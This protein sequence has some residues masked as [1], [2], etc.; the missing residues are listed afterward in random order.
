MLCSSD[1]IAELMT[2][3]VLLQ[4]INTISGKMIAEAQ[5][6]HQDSLKENVR[7]LTIIL[8]H[9]FEQNIGISFF[10]RGHGTNPT[11]W[12]RAWKKI[13][14]CKLF[15]GLGSVHI[16]VKNC[17]LR[18]ENAAQGRRPRAT[19]TSPRSQFFTIRT[20]QLANNTYLSVVRRSND[21]KLICETLKSHDILH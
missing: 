2:L 3:L 11:I 7:L 10:P 9:E 14:T 5:E 16:L 13:N 12:L 19:F 6:P 18:L 20:S 15:T 21:N 17:G 4:H 1:P 8:L